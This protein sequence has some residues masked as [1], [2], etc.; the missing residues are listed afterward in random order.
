MLFR[1]KKRNDEKKGLNER[2][3]AI[4]RNN[5]IGCFDLNDGSINYVNKNVKKPM[6]MKFIH[7]ILEE[8]Y[9]DDVTKAEEMEQYIL[10]KCEVVTKE[11]IVRKVKKGCTVNTENDIR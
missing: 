10:S 4:M 7:R 6:N 5:E 11:V 9:K 2:L 3:L 8:Y 1:S